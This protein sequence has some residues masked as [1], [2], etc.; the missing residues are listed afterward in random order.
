[1]YNFSRINNC[2]KVVCSGTVRPLF[3][4]PSGKRYVFRSIPEESSKN[5]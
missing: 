1:M 2:L 4:D 3:G 5:S